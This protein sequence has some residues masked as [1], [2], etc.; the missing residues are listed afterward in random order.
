MPNMVGPPSFRPLM[1]G[2]S[3]NLFQ[4]VVLRVGTEKCMSDNLNTPK[5]ILI[6][7]Y[8]RQLWPWSSMPVTENGSLLFSSGHL[9]LVL[10]NK[11][12][13]I[14]YSLTW[15]AL[16]YLRYFAGYFQNSQF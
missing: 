6:Y 14:D 9:E 1:V 12:Q 11:K 8:I 4:L 15:Q 10:T 13:K 7:Q 5:Y 3:P 2:V 16:D